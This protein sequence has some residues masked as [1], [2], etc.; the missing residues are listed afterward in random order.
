MRPSGAIPGRVGSAPVTVDTTTLDR[1]QPTPTSFLS[2]RAG[3]ILASFVMLFAE[4]ALIRWVAAY[5]IYVAYFTNFVLLASFLGIGVGFL[6]ARAARP[7]HAWAPLALAG[8]AF[9]VF[10]LRVVKGIDPERNI[11]TSFDLP[12]PPSW[13]DLP[14][15]FLGAAFAMALVAEEVARRFERFEPLEAY[16]LDITGSLVGI[17]AFS[18]MSFLGIGPLLWGFVLAVSFILLAGG[19]PGLRG[20]PRRVGGSIALIVV[21]ALG[22]LAPLDTWS[23][24]YRVTVY[25][26]ASDGRIGDPR[27]LPATPVDLARRATR[28]RS[29]TPPVHAPR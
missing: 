23:P 9:F 27:Q 8:Y 17:I 2:E 21:F 24:Y 19:R 13:V 16:R 28:D 7:L 6:R 26:V 22:S 12:A 15:L 14:L 5:Q 10:A 1:S 4:L 18:T 25:P 20:H 3:L 29:S 11:H